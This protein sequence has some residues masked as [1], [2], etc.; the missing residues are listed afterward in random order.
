MPSRTVGMS[1][2]KILMIIISVGGIAVLGV[3]AGN[4]LNQGSNYEKD[5]GLQ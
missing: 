4:M 3:A 1:K 2:K 5:S